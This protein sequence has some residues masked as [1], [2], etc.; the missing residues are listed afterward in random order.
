MM[1]TM[2]ENTNKT[3][4]QMAAV[5]IL[6]SLAVVRFSG[7]DALKFLQG[8]LTQDMLGEKGRLLIAGYCSPK[9]R[10]LATPRLLV[11]S[12]ES[13]LAIFP[14]TGL[15]SLLKRLRMYVL[16][17]KVAISVCE[18]LAV[19][20]FVGSAPKTFAGLPVYAQQSGTAATLIAAAVPAGRAIAIAQ[21][22]ELPELTRCESLYWMATAAAGD[23]WVF[24]Q[25]REMFVPQGINLECVGGVS[26]TKGCYTG[27]EVVS[28]VEHIG[29]TAR[30]A[31]LFAAN[32][33]IAAAPG[34]DLMIG[35]EPAGIV[36]QIAKRAGRTLVLAQ[37]E[38]AQTQSKEFTLQGKPLYPLA[39]PYGYQR[40]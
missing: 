14:K 1:P 22:N 32:E 34:A 27:Q 19:L 30:R 39:L 7:A 4:A 25:T 29:K 33:E 40:Q 20:G 37:V 15:S 24:E 8:Q 21:R 12:D 2:S 36:V 17:S 28:R 26:F 31:A 6:D 18:E 9:G 11:E 10:L 38:T 35:G 13:A 5:S 3:A 23:P 16:R